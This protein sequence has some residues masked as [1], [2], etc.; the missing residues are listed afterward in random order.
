MGDTSEDRAMKE[1]I[2]ELLR[3]LQ[4]LDPRIAAAIE[5]DLHTTMATSEQVED[6]LVGMIRRRGGKTD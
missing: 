5:I 1:R 6:M 4:V 2:E 3:R